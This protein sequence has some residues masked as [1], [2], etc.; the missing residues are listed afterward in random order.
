MQRLSLSVIAFFLFAVPA[1]AQIAPAK[2]A[3]T[4]KGSALVDD[5]K[6]MTLYVF[7]RDAPGK[8]NCNGPCATNWP[9]FA[10]PTG[11]KASGDWT[12]VTRDDGGMQWAYKGKPLY[13]FSKDGKPG[14]ATGD[15]FN[16]VWHIAAP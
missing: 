14:D 2:A 10:A 9:P 15:D 16:H 3:P 12:V 7:D 8:S 1:F 6:G 13:A 5:A 4:S 11:A